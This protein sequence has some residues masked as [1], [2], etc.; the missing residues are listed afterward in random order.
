M[1]SNIKLI[2]GIMIGCI[3]SG[4][5][6]AAAYSLLSKDIQ[7]TP[8]NPNWQAGNVEDAL[9]SLYISRA[10]NEYSTEEKVVGKWIDG[11]PIYQKTFILTSTTNNME[12][13]DASSLNVDQ[14]IDG[15]ARV[16]LVDSGVSYM[17]IVHSNGT[18]KYIGYSETNKFFY[19]SHNNASSQ[20]RWRD[21]TVQYTKTTDQAHS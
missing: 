1:K 11:K 12:N 6:G 13:V 21:L 15:F 17:T 16:W 14:F 8:D 7:F 3:I 2:I 9:N 18:G 10:N 4:G 20:K 5:I 19:G